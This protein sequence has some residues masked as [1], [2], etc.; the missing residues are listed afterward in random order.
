MISMLKKV[1][2]GGRGS[3]DLTRCSHEKKDKSQSYIHKYQ[4]HIP[5]L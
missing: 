1:K 3:S 4:I 2:F 5:Q